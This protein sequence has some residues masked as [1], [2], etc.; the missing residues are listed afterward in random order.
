MGLDMAAVMRQIEAHAEDALAAGAQVI[1]DRSQELVPKES[2]HLAE[3]A[4]VN[5][6]GLGDVVSITYDGPYAHYQHESME[7]KHPTGGQAKFLETAMLEKADEAIDTVGRE[8]R[9][10]LES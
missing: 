4:K 2:G 1:L 5:A 7:F 10:A 9:A 6:N 3:G 8:L